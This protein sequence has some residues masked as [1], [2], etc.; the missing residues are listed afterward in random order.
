MKRE[1][2]AIHG[3]FDCDP[4]TKAAPA[5]IYQ[6]AAYSFD[7]AEHGAALFNLENPCYRYTRIANPTT[8]VLLNGMA[9]LEGGAEALS[10]TSGQAALYCAILTVTEVGRN[11]VSVPQLYGTTHTLFAHLLPQFGIQCRFAKSDQAV[12]LGALID[13][14]TSAGFCET[15]GNPAGN[16][17]DLEAIASVAH[18]AGVPLIVDN[19]VPTPILVRPFEF[20]ADIVL[21]S[22]TK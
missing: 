11:I 13:D 21:H 15:V 10:V 3:G 14:N 6:T 4:A 20:G 1:T 22:L 5:P 12:D 19:T 18:R 16:V 17:C 8:D 2:I 9:L 7:S